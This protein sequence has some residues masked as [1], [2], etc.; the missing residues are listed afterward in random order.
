MR[1]T[2]RRPRSRVRQ[3]RRH[4]ALVESIELVA[5]V[6]C[7]LLRTEATSNNVTDFGVPKAIA[8]VPQ[9]WPAMAAVTDRYL[10]IQQDILETFVDRVIS[11][12]T[13]TGS[14]PCATSSRRCAPRGWSNACFTPG[15]IDYS[16]RLSDLSDFLEALRT[17]VRPTDGRLAQPRH[18]RRPTRPAPS[19]SGAMIRLYWTGWR[20]CEQARR[21]VSAVPRATATTRVPTRAATYSGRTH[22]CHLFRGTDRQ[23][24]ICARNNRC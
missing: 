17:R 1:R 19:R 11:R 18:G 16:A 6:L 8:A 20:S 10:T 4:K 2:S 9:L 22:N 23:Y 3:G 14:L 7:L 21:Y 12:P 24:S 15:A 5:F 13:S